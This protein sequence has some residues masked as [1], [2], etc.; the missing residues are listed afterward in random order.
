MAEC[1]TSVV[2]STVHRWALKLLPVLEK[3]FLSRKRSV[4]KDQTT[5]L[6]LDAE[7]RRA[8]TDSSLH[9]ASANVVCCSSFMA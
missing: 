7:S 1:G 2:H 9:R 6:L 8:Q 3:A 4:G 5:L